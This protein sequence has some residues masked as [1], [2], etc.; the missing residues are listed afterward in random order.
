MFT[1]LRLAQLFEER[2]AFGFGSYSHLDGARQKALVDPVEDR[3][4]I[5]KESATPSRIA[6]F[7]SS[8]TRTTSTTFSRYWLARSSNGASIISAR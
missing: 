1:T 8:A 6:P 4:R 5:L 7:Y 2:L 3:A